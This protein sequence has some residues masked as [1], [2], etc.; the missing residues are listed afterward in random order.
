MKDDFKVTGDIAIKHN[1][2]APSSGLINI[3]GISK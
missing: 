2:L 1:G 3:L